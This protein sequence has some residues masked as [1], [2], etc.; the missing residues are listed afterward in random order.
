MVGGRP[1]VLDEQLCFLAA[2][3]RTRPQPASDSSD[4]DKPNELAIANASQRT[5]SL[6]QPTNML[7]ASFEVED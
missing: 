2:S 1:R 7:V 6:A 5:C 3:D 4:E